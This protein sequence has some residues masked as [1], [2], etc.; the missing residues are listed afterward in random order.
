[1]KKILSILLLSIIFITGCGTKK[2][3]N[4]PT[5]KVEM[6]FSKYQSLDDEVVDQLKE[7]TNNKMNFTE[8]NKDD[9]IEIMK[10]HYQTLK[11]EIKDEVINGNSATVT[12]EIEVMD[13]SKILSD[14]DKYLESHRDEFK[15]ES[16]EYS[17]QLFNKYRIDKLKQAEDK[18]K[19]TIDINLT[20]IDD[21]WVIDDLDNDTMDKIQG[22]Y[23]YGT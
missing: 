20:K 9:Y 6:F 23:V 12:A 14:A 2:L 17:E 7:I 4:T 1:M 15:N 18:V 11:Y 10:K 21:E 13:Y 3:F 19:Y 22:V 5:K 8:E 16:G